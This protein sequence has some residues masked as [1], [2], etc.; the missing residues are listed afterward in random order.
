MLGMGGMVDELGIGTIRD[1]ISDVLFPGMSTLYTRAKYFFITPYILQ[2]RMR[3]LKNNKDLGRRYFDNKE[4]EANKEI[5]NFYNKHPNLSNESYFGKNAGAHLR[6]QPSAIYWSGM[7]HFQFVNTAESLDQL[8]AD[9]KSLVSEL[10]MPL[11][12]NGRQE[13]FE[14]GETDEKR[15]VNIEY[16]PD[17]MDDLRKH[18]AHLLTQEAET[19]FDRITMTDPDS[20]LTAL[21]KDGSLWSMYSNATPADKEL[22]NRFTNFAYMAVKGGMIKNKILKRNLIRANDL[23]IFLYGQHAVYNLALHIVRQDKE[24]TEMY[25][26]LC[27]GWFTKR[28]SLMLDPDGFRIETYFVGVNVKGPT[29]T[30]LSTQQDLLDSSESWDSIEKQYI[31][32]VE[33][34]EQKNKGKKSRFYKMAHEETVDELNDGSWLGLKLIEYRYAAGR[35]IINDILTEL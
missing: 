29:R 25:R 31:K 7:R 3:D 22:S 11:N 32:L 26:S 24:Y 13:T 23:A 35:S 34:Q 2:D 27:K 16:N 30:F 19:L 28:K 18:G 20:L 8:L 1:N 5:I 12:D 10:L 15:K 14:E 33:R 9:K 21:L 6:R 17:W 4:E